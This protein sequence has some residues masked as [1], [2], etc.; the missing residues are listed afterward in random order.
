MV[1]NK[2]ATAPINTT[3]TDMLNFPS[4]RF[5]IKRKA[6]YAANK[7]HAPLAKDK[8]MPDNSSNNTI[9]LHQA[10]MGPPTPATRGMPNNNNP[11]NWLCP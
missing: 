1:N 7:I 4:S 9:F 10:G 8:N 5:V 6:K 2:A 3:A 11:A